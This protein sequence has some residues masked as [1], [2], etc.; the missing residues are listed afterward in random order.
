MS[1]RS[2][3]YLSL[4]VTKMTEKNKMEK[5]FA[6]KVCE[7]STDRPS[8]LKVHIKAVHEKIKDHACGQC[9]QAFARKS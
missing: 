1:I 5:K 4:R 2:H 6:C 9:A 7:Y 3:V 8:H